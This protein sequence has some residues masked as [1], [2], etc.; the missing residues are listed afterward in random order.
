MGMDTGELPVFT[1]R[2]SGMDGSALQTLFMKKVVS[3]SSSSGTSVEYHTRICSPA[4]YFRS[5][6]RRFDLKAVPQLET[7]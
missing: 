4:E 3:F 5:L 1:P 2:S 6:L 7:V